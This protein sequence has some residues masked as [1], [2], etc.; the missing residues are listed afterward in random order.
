MCS[1]VGIG[2]PSG[3]QHHWHGSC[4]MRSHRNSALEVV[5]TSPCL[6]IGSRCTGSSPCCWRQR[7]ASRW[8]QR[9]ASIF[10]RSSMKR[11]SV[12]GKLVASWWQEFE[13]RNDA[14]NT[15]QPLAAKA[16]T[17]GQSSMKRPGVGG[18]IWEIATSRQI[19]P[20]LCLKGQPGGR[21]S[22]WRSWG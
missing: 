13:D 5:E 19:Q 4:L 17:F 6:Q 15:S 8:R 20:A 2:L 14:A 10:G 16:S 18:R 3:V 21:R 12:G 7:Q 22:Q 1:P 11:P 9:P